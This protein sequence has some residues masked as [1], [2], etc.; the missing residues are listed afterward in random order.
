MVEMASQFPIKII[1]QFYRTDYALHFVC[2]NN[3]I[4]VHDK[5]DEI[6]LI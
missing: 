1:N 4:I 2:Y 3:S 5:A 6:A